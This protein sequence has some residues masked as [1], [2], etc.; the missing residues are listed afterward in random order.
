MSRDQ[1]IIMMEKLQPMSVVDP[2]SDDSRWLLTYTD[3]ITLIL[4]LFVL[5]LTYASFDERGISKPGSVINTID[6]D[7]SNKPDKAFLPIELLQI[8][9]E[10]LQR[11]KQEKIEALQAKVDAL[12][13]SQSNLKSRINDEGVY[14][15]LASEILFPI[16]RAALNDSGRALVQQAA[17]VL[18]RTDNVVMIEGH[19]D[20]IPIAT[21]QFPSN[22]ELS[23]ARATAVLRQLQEEGI[24]KNRMRAVAFADT[25]PLF[26]N[27]TPQGRAENRRVSILL[28]TQ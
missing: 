17:D 12:L 28:K 9:Q 1:D 8:T 22:W 25:Q 27:N 13:E 14:L 20:S 5:L 3:I 6:Q 21:R 23:A 7:A 24:S 2:A 11:Q 19:T 15:D 18:K 10:R 26:L 16:G 4:T